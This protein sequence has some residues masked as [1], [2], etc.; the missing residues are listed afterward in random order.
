MV[1]IAGLLLSVKHYVKCCVALSH[2]F[3][4]WV[5]IVINPIVIDKGKGFREHAVDHRAR[6]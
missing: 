6:R 4:F 3:L 2:S 5:A 1:T